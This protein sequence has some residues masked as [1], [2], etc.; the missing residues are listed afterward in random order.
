MQVLPGGSQKDSEAFSEKHDIFTLGIESTSAA[1]RGGED[2]DI[3][4]FT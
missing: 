1:A 4:D 2:V 3:A